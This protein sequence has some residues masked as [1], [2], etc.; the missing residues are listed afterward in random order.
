MKFQV[1]FLAQVHQGGDRA[2][3]EGAIREQN[4]RGMK[5]EPA[6]GK[7]GTL[8]MRRVEPWHLRAHADRKKKRSSAGP[9]KTEPRPK[10]EQQIKRRERPGD[11]RGGLRN[12]LNRGGPE[13]A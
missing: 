13:A 10:T 5:A 7:R 2:K 9:P 12:S 8:S 3:P 6:A 11:G 4:Q 1:V